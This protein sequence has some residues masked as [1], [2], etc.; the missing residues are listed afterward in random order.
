VSLG[1]VAVQGVFI[2]YP[3]TALRIEAE[4][5][6]WVDNV[7]SEKPSAMKTAT[8]QLNG[9]FS[10]LLDGFEASLMPRKTSTS[11]LTVPKEP[12]DLLETTSSTVVLTI[13]A[14]N[15]DVQLDKKMTGELLRPTLKKPPSRLRYELIYVSTALVRCVLNIGS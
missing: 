4:E 8:H 1:S 10:P 14:A 3:L 2:M 9:L 15:V 13:F 11:V 6:R 12:I 7:S 5:A